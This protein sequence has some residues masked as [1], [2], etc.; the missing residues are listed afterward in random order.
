[1]TENPQ[2]EAA[3]GKTKTLRPV[4]PC[5]EALRNQLLALRDNSRGAREPITNST[6]AAEMGYSSGA[7]SEYLNERGNLWKNV[8]ELERRIREWLR[9][10]T[11][12]LDTNIETISCDVADQMNDAFEDIRTARELGVI[13]GKPGIGKTRGTVVYL[14]DH[15]LSILIEC[16]LGMRSLNDVMIEIFKQAEV[17]RPRRGKNPITHLFES[18][19]GTSRLFIFDDAHKLSRMALQLI[20]DFRDKTGA[21]VALLGDERLLEKLRDDSQ[22]LRRVGAVHYLKA[23]NP[24][25]II[26]HQI[27]SLIPETDGE[28][29][30]LALLCE[31]IAAREGVFG[32]V[33]KQLKRAIRLKKGEPKWSWTECVRH[34]HRRLIR[35]YELA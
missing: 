22:R 4:H 13:I 10:R 14:R 18:M 23:K 15:E 5:D 16:W 17:A 30:A 28:T 1:M 32:S 11:I 33:E 29:K 24:Q 6:F 12:K 8:A 2:T 26:K 34:A 27:K 7:F 9:D 20:I 25:E 19:R 21:P 31:Q 35:D 3:E